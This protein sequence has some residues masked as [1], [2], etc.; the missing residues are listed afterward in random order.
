MKIT[1]AEILKAF[2]TIQGY[3]SAIATS[4]RKI[5]KI[6]ETKFYKMYNIDISDKDKIHRLADKMLLELIDDR[7]ITKAFNSFFKYYI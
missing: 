3:Q 5:E 4:D 7:E 1:K 6:L 2:W